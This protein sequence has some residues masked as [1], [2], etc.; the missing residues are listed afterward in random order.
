MTRR[1]RVCGHTHVYLDHALQSRRRRR[2]QGERNGS[3]RRRPRAVK[4][5]RACTGGS[6]RVLAHTSIHT[7]SHTTNPDLSAPL[8]CLHAPPR[9]LPPFPSD[10]HLSPPSPAFLSSF[11]TPA[12]TPPPSCPDLRPSSPSRSESARVFPSLSESAMI[13]DRRPCESPTHA[14]PKFPSV[15]RGS[16]RVGPSLSESIKVYPSLFESV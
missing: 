2:A 15:P 11:L 12:P 3:T 6:N 9:P 7:T 13:D 16:V 8:L 1:S 10:S 5:A 4:R 14:A